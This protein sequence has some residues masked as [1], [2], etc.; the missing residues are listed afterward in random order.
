MSKYHKAFRRFSGSA[1]PTDWD[2]RY[3]VA[4]GSVDGR[5]VLSDVPNTSSISSSFEEWE[6]LPG[7]REVPMSDF[8]GPKSVFYAVNDFERSREL[9]S[10]ISESGEIKPLIIAIDDE[11]PYLLEGAHR[12]VALHELGAKSFPALVI[13]DMDDLE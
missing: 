9:A 3:P 2:S 12:F 7:I 10:Q 13:I 11:G 6:E 5:T 1:S 8:G 4:G